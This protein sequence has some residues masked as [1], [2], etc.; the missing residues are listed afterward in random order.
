MAA[1]RF[2]II[3]VDSSWVFEFSIEISKSLYNTRQSSDWHTTHRATDSNVE[4]QNDALLVA[5]V[6]TLIPQ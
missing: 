6:M 1:L 3:G 2:H 4:P 5:I